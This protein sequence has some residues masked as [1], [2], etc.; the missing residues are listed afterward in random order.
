MVSII[1]KFTIAWAVVAFILF[2]LTIPYLVILGPRR[3]FRRFRSWLS[4]T[5][6]NLINSLFQQARQVLNP[7]PIGSPQP[8]AQYP[9]ESWGPRPTCG[10]LI[11]EIKC[12]C[13][14]KLLLGQP[15]PCADCEERGGNS[16]FHPRV[17]RTKRLDDFR[18]C[19]K[20]LVVAIFLLVCACGWLLTEAQAFSHM[21][22][23]YRPFSELD[24][25]RKWTV[26]ML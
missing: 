4:R 23:C 1:L 24:E 22:G 13:C 16:I 3:A 18:L 12:D 6:S 10:C 20:C 19:T 7:M 21:P 2:L 8:T 11:V 15:L 14:D 9:P 5:P 25:R 17:R 26:P